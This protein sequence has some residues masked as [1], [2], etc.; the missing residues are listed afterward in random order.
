MLKSPLYEIPL[1]DVVVII[2]LLLFVRIAII[3]LKGTNYE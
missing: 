3:E 1:L 2:G